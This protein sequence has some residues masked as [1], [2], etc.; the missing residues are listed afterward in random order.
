MRRPAEA[1]R[2][3][4]E[5]DEAGEGRRESESAR[6]RRGLARG[7]RG[8]RDGHADGYR[9]DDRER[10]ASVKTIDDLGERT[11]ER[12]MQRLWQR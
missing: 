10:R 1:K 7:G 8:W 3:Y 11:I 2:D 6:E 4:R 5:N 9:D 12:W